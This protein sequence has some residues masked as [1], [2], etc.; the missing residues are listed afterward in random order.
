MINSNNRFAIDLLSVVSTLM[1]EADMVKLTHRFEEV[2]A[3]YTIERKTLVEMEE[4]I[5]EKIDT[6]ISS[7]RIEGLAE[8]TLI[9]Y[10]MELFL[11]AGH[12]KAAAAQVTAVD[13]RNY[14]ASIKGVMMSTIGKKLS[15]LKSFFGWLLTEEMILRDPTAKVK[16]PKKPKRLKKSLSIEELENVREV[17]ADLRERALLEVFYSTA[18]RLSEIAGMDTEHINWQDKSLRVIGKGDKERVVYLS[19]KCIYHLKKYL[20]ARN[21]DCPALFVTVRRPYRRLKNATIQQ[22]IDK[23]EQRATISKK[24]T[25]H[26]MRH[27]FAQ[28][29]LDAG[30]ELSDLQHILG[31][32]SPSTTMTYAEVSEERKQQAHK[33]YHVQ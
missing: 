23:I 7:K 25:P 9:D 12:C 5:P 32:S 8:G 1:P 28:L 30:M 29:S 31:H 16:T 14:L 15:V 20:D 2:M 18:C 6:Y 17:C 21:D 3:N 19:S 22:I 4:D 27:T 13:I 33:K 11:F 26:V 10:R 24:L